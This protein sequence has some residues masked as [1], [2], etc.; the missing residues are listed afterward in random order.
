MAEKKSAAKAKSS[1]APK[2]VAPVEAELQIEKSVLFVTSE[3]N[4]FAGTGGLAD[5]AASLPKAIAENGRTDMRVAMPLYSDIDSA[6]RA[7]FR[8]EGNFNVPLGWRN[9]YCGLFSLK[10]ECVTFYF[11]DNDYYFKRKG[12]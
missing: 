1:G 6:Y 12:L 2:K 9:Q 3:A 8:F 4:P 11:L 7:N 10:F 5:V